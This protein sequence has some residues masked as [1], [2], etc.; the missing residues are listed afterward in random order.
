[1]LTLT[2]RIFKKKDCSSDT[3][4]IT[5]AATLWNEWLSSNIINGLDNDMKANN[6]QCD[7]ISKSE[8]QLVRLNSDS[9]YRHASEKLDNNENESKSHE[10]TVYTRDSS[11]N[12][13]T[14]SS[15]SSTSSISYTDSKDNCWEKVDNNIVIQHHCS[16]ESFK[17][18]SDPEDF[19]TQDS[20]GNH[21]S[22]SSWDSKPWKKT[23]RGGKR[24]KAQRQ[25][26]LLNQQNN[27]KEIAVSL[28]NA[29]DPV[30]Y[31]TELWKNW[32]ETGKW[33]YSIRCNFAHGNHELVSNEAVNKQY[34][35]VNCESYHN[36]SFWAY[37][38]RWQYWH[39]IRKWSD[40]EWSYYN[41]NLRLLE[42]KM[43]NILDPF[44]VKLCSTKTQPSKRLKIFE[45]LA[46]SSMVLKQNINQDFYISSQNAPNNIQDFHELSIQKKRS[47]K[48]KFRTSKSELTD[49]NSIAS[50]KAPMHCFDIMMKIMSSSMIN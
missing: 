32:I 49:I 40:I 21:Q 39:D 43:N 47:S 10:L 7:N 50:F 42:Q 20:D 15:Y 4:L 17:N 23:R 14:H 6:E 3:K 5:E 16:D 11:N 33:K 41:K 9:E 29:R 34:K 38:S 35:R 48:N 12:L 8:Y 13:N 24:A 44:N 19:D 26:K 18:F 37:G 25:R 46:P 1:M 30:K 22:D 45:S 36:E 2:S 31:K 27:D 28:E